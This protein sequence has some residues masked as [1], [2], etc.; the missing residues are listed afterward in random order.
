MNAINELYRLRARAKSAIH[1]P[2]AQARK[3]AN[4]KNLRCTYLGDQSPDPQLN[5]YTR[6]PANQKHYRNTKTYS[7]TMAPED[8]DRLV[9][10]GKELHIEGGFSGVLTYI[11][12][13]CTLIHEKT[14]QSANLNISLLN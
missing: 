14:I 13:N 11:A 9:Q 4:Q 5:N 3:D 2:T 1:K 10:L 6:V 7:I 12:Q 8:H